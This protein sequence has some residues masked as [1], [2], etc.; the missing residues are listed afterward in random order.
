MQMQRMVFS[1]KQQFIDAW[2]R[3]G[4]LLYVT[5]ELFHWNPRTVYRPLFH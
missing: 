2:Q 1:V 3:K 5:V 4:K